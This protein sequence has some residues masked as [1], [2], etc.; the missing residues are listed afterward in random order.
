MK[1]VRFTRHAL[2]QCSERGASEAE[3]TQA[4]EHGTWEPARLGR[5]LCKFNFAYGGLWQGKPY[6]IKQVDPVIKEESDEIVVV[7]VYTFYF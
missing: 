7:T 1:P 6:A 5:V 4:I 3:I 2:D